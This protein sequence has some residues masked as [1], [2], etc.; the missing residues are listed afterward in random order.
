MLG[1]IS[2]AER[3]DGQSKGFDDYGSSSNPVYFNSADYNGRQFLTDAAVDAGYEK[4]VIKP[5]ALVLEHGI[6]SLVEPD[7]AQMAYSAEESLLGI[8]IAHG[9]VRTTLK[10]FLDSRNAVASATDVLW[11]SQDREW[12][13][14][15]L[16]K[17]SE[18]LP[19]A[20]SNPSELKCVLSQLP[21]T[22]PGAF[23]EVRNNENTTEQSE[24]T[25]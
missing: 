8:L 18:Y 13:F 4:C 6:S 1:Q 12:L 19:E 5:N 2:P 23:Y 14:D 16:V 15:T 21:N 25:H 3:R 7:F 17:N 10:N 9:P 22:P 20:S 11:S 24:G